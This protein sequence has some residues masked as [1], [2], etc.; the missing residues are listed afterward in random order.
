MKSGDKK[1]KKPK[2]QGGIAGGILSFFSSGKEQ[3]VPDEPSEWD[4][5]PEWDGELCSLE[6]MASPP[7]VAKFRDRPL[8]ILHGEG[9]LFYDGELC[10]VA[11]AVEEAFFS[12]L[13]DVKDLSESEAGALEEGAHFF[14]QNYLIPYRGGNLFLPERDTVRRF[15]GNWYPRKSM[16]PDMDEID[17]LLVAVAALYAYLHHLGLT[18]RKKAEEIISECKDRDFYSYRLQGYWA[19]GGSNKYYDWV[20]EYDYE[21]Y[22][23]EETKID[24]PFD[25]EFRSIELDT[26]FRISEKPVQKMTESDCRAAHRVVMKLDELLSR[27]CEA[28]GADAESVGRYYLERYEMTRQMNFIDGLI[29]LPLNISTAGFVDEA[30]DMARRLSEYLE[31]EVF[32]GDAVTILSEAGRHEEAVSRAEENIKNFPGAAWIHITAAEAYERA[33]DPGKSMEI[34][35]V[36][37]DVIKDNT[38]RRDVYE[39]FIEFLKRTGKTDEAEKLEE[40]AREEGCDGYAAKPVGQI[41]VSPGVDHPETA[42]KGK[43]KKIG[44]NDP[45]PCGSGKKYKK[46]CLDK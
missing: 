16:D 43:K 9:E 21:G 29:C 19:A 46:C 30:L 2:K 26:L 17:L 6:P 23:L 3:V 10:E 7:P 20:C 32:L 42:E 39:R 31:P 15:L 27:V 34:F 8:M 25:K 33:G 45:C 24:D 5:P 14:L 4:E 36:A 44:R 41:M 12:F 1:K 40:Q 28:T 18:P 22:T 35:R 13:V 37:L 38:L 11:D